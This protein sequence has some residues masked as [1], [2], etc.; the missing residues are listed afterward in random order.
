MKQNKPVRKDILAEF[1]NADS[2]GKELLERLFGKELFSSKVTDRVKS[3]EDAF[4]ETGR[5]ATPEFM[6][7]PEDMRP[8]F[9]DLYNG[10][11]YAEAMNEGWKADYNDGN[12]QKWLPYFNTLSSSGFTFLDTL[13]VYSSPAAGDAARLCLKDKS[14]AKHAGEEITEV[15]KGI[16]TK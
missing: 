15:Y 11:V 6:D 16:I 2:K 3:L 13:F 10:A 5:P 1:R 7:A 14:L 4:E 8:W 12:Q 9:Q